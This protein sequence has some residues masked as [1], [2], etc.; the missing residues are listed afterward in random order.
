MKLA[1]TARRLIQATTLIETV[2]AA[3]L[4]AAFFGTL[5]ELNAVCFRYIDSS[6]ES[7][8]ALEGVHDRLEALRGLSFSNLTSATYI[9]SMMATPANSSDF[10]Q[11]VQEVVTI[12]D[13]YNSGTATVFTRPAGATPTVTASPSSGADFSTSKLVKVNVTYTWTTTF[14]GRTMSEQSETIIAAGNK[15]A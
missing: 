1:P 14:G 7:V 12:T 9:K 6:K 13:L 11:R 5:Y 4:I 8:G 15:K 3:S 2:V 10:V